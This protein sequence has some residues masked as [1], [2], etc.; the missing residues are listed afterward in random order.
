MKIWATTLWIAFLGFI[1]PV[2]ASE[3]VKVANVGAENTIDSPR[4]ISSKPIT[5]KKAEFG[6]LRTEK[7]GKFT[8]IPTTKV[9]FQEGQIYGWRIQI[10]DYQGEL[11]W[12]EV[13]TLPKPPLTWGTDNG[14]HFFL[15]PDGTKS[16]IKRTAKVK[17]G[18]VSNFWTVSTGDPTGKY[19]LE[20]YVDKHKI[21]SFK[22][23]I[24][25]SSK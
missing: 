21:A 5:V 24:V 8:F 1:S 20:V 25:Q 9:P 23:E 12:L 17:K 2:N 14:E 7:N 6:V 19:I 4:L 13:L 15:S 16:V 3:L 11:T 18:V 10:Q 22:F